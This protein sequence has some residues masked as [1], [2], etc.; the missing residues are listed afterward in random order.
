[1]IQEVVFNCNNIITLL[2]YHKEPVLILGFLWVRNL[3][4]SK[5]LNDTHQSSIDI[6]LIAS[7]P[8]A[9]SIVSSRTE[10]FG[11]DWPDDQ[12]VVPSKV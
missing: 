2:E 5:L 4:S 6:V 9:H 8:T 12:P 1:M 11:C 7:D 3:P 10:L